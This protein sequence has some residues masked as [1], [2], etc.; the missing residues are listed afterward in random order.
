VEASSRI[1]VVAGNIATGKTHL[2]GALSSALGLRS[3]P[4]RW[5]A[6]PWLDNRFDPFSSQMWFL[7]ATAADHAR[8]S[9]GGGVQERCVHDNAQVFARELLAGEDLRLLEDV[10]KRLDAKLP[11]PTLLLHLTASAG[12]LHERVRER[13]RAEERGVTIEYLQHLGS[14]YRELIDG[15][16]RCPV[17][18]VDTE[19]IDLRT[20]EGVRHVLDRTTEK[21]P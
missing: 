17:V 8:M 15:W 19:S 21:L 10:Y 18:E 12:A 3:F 11:D 20:A 2:I 9:S 1:V 14:R 4:E 16:I 6:N 13:Q 7:L 5:A